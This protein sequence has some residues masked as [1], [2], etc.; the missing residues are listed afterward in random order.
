M[1]LVMLRRNALMFGV[2]QKR[3]IPSEKKEAWKMGGVQ[4]NMDKAS[5]FIEIYDPRSKNFA[6][7][8]GEK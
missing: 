2:I 4:I 6:A 5:E 7:K 3:P 1:T 8:G